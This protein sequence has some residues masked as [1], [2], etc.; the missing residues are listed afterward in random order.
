M[1]SAILAEPNIPVGTCYL[2]VKKNTKVDVCH[3]QLLRCDGIRQMAEPNSPSELATTYQE[4]REKSTCVIASNYCV[5]MV[6][7]KW[8]TGVCS[9]PPTRN[10]KSSLPLIAAFS[11]LTH[12]R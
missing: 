6:S 1:V 10:R 5:A 9:T 3:F 4:K 2:T 8:R 7:A 12:D 11:A